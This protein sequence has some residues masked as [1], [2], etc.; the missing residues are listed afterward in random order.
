C[1]HTPVPGCVCEAGACAACRDRCATAA[2][3]CSDGCW[4]AFTSC[5]AGC[6]TTYCAPF[7][8]VDLGRCLSACPTAPPCQDACDAASGCGAACTPLTPPDDTDGDGVPD[9]T[10][11]CVAD[12]NPT[13]SDLDGD[14]IGDACDADDGPLALAQV[15]LRTASTANGRIAIDG[16]Y[17]ATAP[18]DWLDAGAELMLEVATG[19]GEPPVVVTWPVGTC[20]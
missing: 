15:T 18:T 6:T 10:D 11:N 2:T 7:C 4:S 20:A 17:V 12:P 14:G 19:G 13:Q 16:S 9:A 1:S 5:L 3:S 8:Q